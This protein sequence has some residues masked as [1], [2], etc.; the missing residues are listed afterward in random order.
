MPQKGGQTVPQGFENST[1]GQSDTEGLMTLLGLQFDVFTM[2]DIRQIL[3]RL[4]VTTRKNVSK[5]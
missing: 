4:G 3:V 5:G 1:K 2:K